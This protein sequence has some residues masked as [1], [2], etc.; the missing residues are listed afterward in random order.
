MPNS[1]SVSAEKLSEKA[2]SPT[3][4]PIT[5]VRELIF[6]NL[7]TDRIYCFERKKENVLRTTP[8]LNVASTLWP[9]LNLKLHVSEE[10]SRRHQQ[11]VFVFKTQSISAVRPSYKSWRPAPALFSLYYFSFYYYWKKVLIFISWVRIM[12]TQRSLFNFFINAKLSTCL[13][14]WNPP[15]SYR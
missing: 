10:I 9:K 11:K 12:F 3:I 4:E 1:I 6:L 15:N 5:F 14:Q 8:I 7:F 2:K 13:I